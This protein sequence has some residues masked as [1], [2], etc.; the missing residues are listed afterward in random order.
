MHS[1]VK[2]IGVWNGKRP[3]QIVG[4][5]LPEATSEEIQAVAG[6]DIQT[7]A[8]KLYEREI[9]CPIYSAG[10]ASLLNAAVLFDHEVDGLILS[11]AGT[12]HVDDWRQASVMRPLQLALPYLAGVPF[13]RLIEIRE[14]IPDAFLEFRASMF[15]IVR[16]TEKEEP[17]HA[18]IVARE[19][20]R[21]E[22]LPAQM[23][24]P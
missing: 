6:E 1:G 5:V 13:E 21:T 22:L 11:K 10:M 18:C 24:P 17:D 16:R 4:E 20:T 23:A 8:R 3:T 14:A 12:P 15:Q 9:S 2:S 19:L 7:E